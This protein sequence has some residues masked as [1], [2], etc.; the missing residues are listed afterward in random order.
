M[1]PISFQFT[2]QWV[3]VFCT[4][5]YEGKSKAGLSD[6]ENPF[7]GIIVDYDSIHVNFTHSSFYEKKNKKIPRTCINVLHDEFVTKALTSIWS[8]GILF[9][10]KSISK[11]R[12]IS[13]EM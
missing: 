6:P 1:R 12:T 3:L 11:F 5:I 13:L 10:Q 2:P 4:V 7:Q 8:N 9:Q